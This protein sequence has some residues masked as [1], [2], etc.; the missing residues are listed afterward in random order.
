MMLNDQ[1]PLS[2]QAL[3]FEAPPEPRPRRPRWRRR[4]FIALPV[5]ALTYILSV[6]RIPYFVIEP[7]PAQDV[8]PLIH[9]SGHQVFPADGQ[10][11]LTSVGFFQPNVYQAFRAWIDRSESIVPERDLIGP[12]Q[13]QQ[14]AVQVA[15]SQMDQSKID[16]AIV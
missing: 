5:V 6:V 12:G 13:T 4:L 15:L 2:E 14:Q 9:V 1:S 7:G 10:L 8:L 3:P 11:L 16:A